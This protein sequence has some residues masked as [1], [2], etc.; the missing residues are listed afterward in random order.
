MAWDLL[1]ES[2]VCP[3]S[4]VLPLPEEEAPP[5][6]SL[7]PRVPDEARVPLPSQANPYLFPNVPSNAPYGL[8][9]SFE[10]YLGF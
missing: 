5:G 9:L 7:V 10:R 8:Q 1:P 3:S 6:G 2:S 4:L